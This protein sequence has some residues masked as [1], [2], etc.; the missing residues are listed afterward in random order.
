VAAI[1]YTNRSIKFN[2]ISKAIK[3]YTIDRR[4]LNI[5]GGYEKIQTLL[6]FI[7]DRNHFIEELGYTLTIKSKIGETCVICMID[8]DS[9]NLIMV[10]C[11]KFVNIPCWLYEFAYHGNTDRV[12]KIINGSNPS[13]E[14]IKH[15]IMGDQ[16]ELVQILLKMKRNHKI[17]IFSI[18]SLLS[19]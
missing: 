9:N 11:N 2:N 15:A 7:A 17:F 8:I 4:K 18:S 3:Y 10:K 19:F 1:I 5:S 16:M 14:C 13:Y 12:L 6:K